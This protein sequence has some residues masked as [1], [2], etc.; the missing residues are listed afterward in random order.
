MPSRRDTKLQSHAVA[1]P[2][3]NEACR[4]TL[5][6]RSLLETFFDAFLLSQGIKS[7]I[8]LI[9]VVLDVNGSI[10]G[11]FWIGVDYLNFGGD[12]VPP[13]RTFYQGS[14]FKT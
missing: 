7:F 2:T 11:C 3:S 5:W 6:N 10:L 1:A 12:T 14:P 13:I 8:C 4:S 9:P